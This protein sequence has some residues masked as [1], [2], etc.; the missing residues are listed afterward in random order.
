MHSFNIPYS[1]EAWCP[2]I[3]QLKKNLLFIFKMETVSF[4]PLQTP[5]L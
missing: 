2:V 1:D 5:D 4:G 3:L